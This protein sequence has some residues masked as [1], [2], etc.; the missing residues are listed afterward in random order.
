M[1]ILNN[2]SFILSYK[3]CIAEHNK[4]DV[5]VYKKVYYHTLIYYS[6]TLLN[7]LNKTAFN[8][9]VYNPNKQTI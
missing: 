6:Q 2:G 4:N 3:K 9:K 5:T 1:E 7:T 8:K